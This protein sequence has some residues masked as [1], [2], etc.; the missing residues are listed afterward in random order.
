MGKGQGEAVLP[1]WLVCPSSQGVHGCC[2]SKKEISCVILCSLADGA[3]I[4]L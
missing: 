2:S 1:W 3:I 4:H